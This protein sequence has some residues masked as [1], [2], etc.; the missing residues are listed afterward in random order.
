MKL[1]PKKIKG[2]NNGND[3]GKTKQEHFLGALSRFKLGGI[4]TGTTKAVWPLKDGTDEVKQNGGTYFEPAPDGPNLFQVKKN[5]WD[6]KWS[7]YVSLQCPEGTY[8]EG[9]KM[10]EILL[11]HYG[12]SGK[13]GCGWV[14]LDNG[15]QIKGDTCDGCRD[16]GEDWALYT[17]DEMASVPII[18]NDNIRQIEFVKDES[19]L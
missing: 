5:N 3:C 9:R 11:G 1:D 10:A 7:A 16:E 13:H 6:N 18:S 12:G 15:C 8:I 19:G 2:N 4:Y 17:P 14:E